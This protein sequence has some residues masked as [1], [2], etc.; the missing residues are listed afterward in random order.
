MVLRH[1][2]LFETVTGDA[3]KRVAAESASRMDLL[4]HTKPF[5]HLL[6]CRLP[7]Q[8]WQPQGIS[9]AAG[10]LPSSL[11]ILSIKHSAKRLTTSDLRGESAVNFA[12]MGVE[13]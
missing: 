9:S 6:E 4:V 13:T 5:S 11:A 3:A 2:D 12:C 1:V 7:S 10:G 8:S